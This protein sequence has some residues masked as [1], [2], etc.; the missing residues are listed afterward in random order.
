MDLVCFLFFAF[1]RSQLYPPPA[2]PQCNL[3]TVRACVQVSGQVNAIEAVVGS[4]AYKG[5]TM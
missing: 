3:N 1:F 4:E 2:L 5:C